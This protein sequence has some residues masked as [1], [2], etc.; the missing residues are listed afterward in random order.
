[1]PP[2]SAKEY[3]YKHVFYKAG[4]ELKG[5]DKYGTYVKRIGN[6]LENIQL[7]DP[8]AIMHAADETGGAKPLG[9]KTKMSTNK[10][11]FL[12]YAPVGSNANAF[13]PKKDT[14]KKQGCKGKIE[15]DSI[16]P[17]MYPTLVFSKVVNPNIII[18]Q[19]THEFSCAG[20]FY[21]WKKQLQC[22]ETVTPFIIYY[23]YTF[24]DTATICGELTSLL[25][26][27]R[28]GMQDDLT[29]SEEF[30]YAKTPEINIRRGVP[31]L[32]GQP[33]QHFCDYLQ[34]M[35]E[36]RQA[37]LIECNVNAIPFLRTLIGY[38]KEWKLAA[39]IWGWHVH[40]AKT[41]DWDSTK[42]D[43]SR[44]IRML[45]DHMCYNMSVIS[46]EVRGILDLNASAEI[47]CPT[48]GN[49][50]GHLS[51]QQTLMKYLKLQDGTHMC[52]ELHPPGP[53]G[54]GY[55]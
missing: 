47:L 5:E 29:L 46:D 2:P 7:V 19:V 27:A 23:L 36:A 55:P 51:L 37:H 16:D 28:Q 31:K 41:V 32:P 50:L 14:N 40:I 24:N 38:M 15:P 45:Q 35:Q 13:K 34:E 12:A 53:S 26:E 1:M 43:V 39:P 52:T 54:H 18:L 42:R 30:E 8:M 49:V 21:F 20:G 6:L 4:L 33:G 9:S 3:R 10:T 48:T 17:S 25:E 44:F 11:V 22:V